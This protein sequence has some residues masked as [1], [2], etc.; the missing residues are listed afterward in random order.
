MDDE[1][2]TTYSGDIIW[3]VSEYSSQ[4]LNLLSRG[5]K[6]WDSYRNRL[7]SD[8]IRLGHLEAS[9]KQIVAL[10][11]DPIN[12]GQRSS[13]FKG[14]VVGAIQSGKTASMIGVSAVA[15]DQGYK[16]IV[17]LTGNS[18]DLRRQ[19]ALR[20]NTQLLGQSDR[21]LGTVP[22]YTVKE[23]RG[24][25]P[26]GGYAPPYHTDACYN[27]ALPMFIDKYLMLDQPIV[28]V[29]K[30]E[31]TNLESLGGALRSV[32]LSAHSS[33]V[34]ILVL[35]DECDEGSV[36]ASGSENPTPQA[37]E[38]IWTSST[39]EMRVAYV[40]YT[41]TAAANLLQDIEN[42]LF[43]SEFGYLL[44]YPQDSDGPLTTYQPDYDDW[45]TGG[46]V[47]YRNFGLEPGEAG[48]FL[49]RTD[50]TAQESQSPL[51][52][53]SLYDALIAFLVGG[54]YRLALQPDCSFDDPSRLP[55]PHSMLI[56][57]SQSM[58]DHE[59]WRDAVKDLL[60]G[61]EQ[62]D[63]TIVFNAERLLSRVEAEEGR[64]KEWFNNFYRS[65]H[66]LHFE[67]PRRA[68]YSVITWEDVAE[69]LG[70]VF[71]HTRLKVVNSD[72]DH[73]SNLNFDS[74]WSSDGEV[75]PEDIY[76]IIIGGQKLSRGI[77]IEGLCVSYYTRQANKPFAD[78]TLQISRWFGYRGRQ[79][80]FCRLFT[81]EKSYSVLLDI[82]ENDQDY[83]LRL[84]TIGDRHQSLDEARIA[85]RESP[86]YRLTAKQGSQ[87]RTYTLA[88][89]PHTK[90][91]SRVE[92]E[93]LAARNEVWAASIIKRAKS[94]GYK[95]MYFAD[96][97][98]KGILSPH[99]SAE[100]IAD[101]LDGMS[102]TDHNPDATLY[103]SP[104]FYRSAESDRPLNRLLEINEDPYQVAAYLRFWAQSERN[105]PP[106]FDIA[107]PFGN[108]VDGNDPFDF[109]L[110]DRAIS[111]DTHELRDSWTGPFYA[112]DEGPYLDEPP[113]NQIDRA[114]H[115]K[116]GSRGLLALYVVHK[117]VGD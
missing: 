43:P 75:L 46:D 25:G 10:L 65:K 1:G 116:K 3:P 108:S 112:R 42:P 98:E 47:F 13:P 4:E 71:S 115:R 33:P 19:T 7:P 2:I 93:S 51:E 54:A 97:T 84:A 82:H 68:E 12:W 92:V 100:N 70:N 113:D 35:D 61:S 50:V 16:V 87:A 59:A 41:A 69:C 105:I 110:L 15:L 29:V 60:G 99:W 36:G 52:N 9:S 62:P 106:L 14:L 27:Q 103:P 30:K 83:R 48:N 28:I 102:L 90:L 74:G 114:G 88:F 32:N 63:R 56:Q 73:G 17:V 57:V 80:E 23:R 64:W 94:H 77:T 49:V 8:D 22:V 20:F 55:K 40:G 109:P 38:Q 37:I 39:E 58:R 85:L 21:R 44:R 81:T 101:I 45:Y 31:V 11:P 53:K 67:R 79:I 26:L 78:S 111:S 96:G 104:E 95:T 24:N 18:E 34:P 6:W 89:S 117:V 76:V 72:P 86:T 5:S 107:I 66:Q 91:Y